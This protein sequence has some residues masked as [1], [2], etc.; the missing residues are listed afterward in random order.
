VT[1]LSVR[2]QEWR[3]RPTLSGA[4]LQN[5]RRRPILSSAVLLIAAATI[6]TPQGSVPS[7]EVTAKIVLEDGSPLASSP[8]I[9]PVTGYTCAAESFL[10]GTLRIK[11]HYLGHASLGCQLSVRLTGY[12][13]FEGWVGD[14]T[15]ITLYR[16]GPHEGAFVSKISL[17][18]PPA[19]KKYY[20]AGEAAAA[21]SKWPRAE[22]QFLA[23]VAAYPQYAA[24]WSELGR[25]LPQQHRLSEAAEALNKSCEADPLYAKP[26]VQLAEVA[27]LEQ[28]W[29]DE[30]RFGQ[31]ALN[32]HPLGFTTA[33][34]S[35][36]E[37]AFHLGSLEQSEKLAREAV[38]LDRD[39]PCPESM[40]LLGTIFEKQGNAPD[41]AVKFKA[42][43]KMAPHGPQ[44]QQAKDALAR[45]RAS[46]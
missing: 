6:A 10:D 25:A 46:R 41:A 20:E 44:A 3:N 17:E 22:E 9:L 34:Y 19:A 1:S 36:A 39:G 7:T 42:Y 40:V 13:P 5:V 27:G 35:C 37:A 28:R 23:A 12:R 38:R 2:S 32:M 8:M 24:A 14:G 29:E 4:K 33:Y 15:L 11:V 26:L 31:Q 21:K 30:M 16:I 45:L 43:L 18:A